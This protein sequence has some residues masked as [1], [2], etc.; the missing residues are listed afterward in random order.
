MWGKQSGYIII[1][2]TTLVNYHPNVNINNNIITYYIVK[3]VLY[4]NFDV[5]INK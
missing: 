2:T 5:N 3:I 4:Y 1:T